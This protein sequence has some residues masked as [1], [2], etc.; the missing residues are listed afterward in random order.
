MIC[1]PTPNSCP[2]QTSYSPS[3][4]LLKYSTKRL[5]VICEDYANS[6]PISNTS[7]QILAK[8]NYMNTYHELIVRVVTFSGWSKGI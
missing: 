1:N 5:N 2:E 7:Y 6:H 8:F 3:L 4:V